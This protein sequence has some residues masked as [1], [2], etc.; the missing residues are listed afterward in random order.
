MLPK[1]I[2]MGRFEDYLNDF[3]STVNILDFIINILVAALL[4]FIIKIFYIKFA[5]TF[6][7]REKFSSIFLP[8]AL[9]TLLIITVVKASI[10]LSLGLVGALS[11]VRF[12]AA[13]KEPEELTYIF[14]IIGI[15]LTCGANKPMLAIAAIALILP[16]I[17]LNTRMG[18][19]K[20]MTKDKLLINIRTAST[21]V[22]VISKALSQNLKYVELKRMEDNADGLFLTFVTQVDDVQSISVIRQQLKS[23]DQNM[24]LT[25]IDQP[26]LIV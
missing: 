6:S 1:E 11:I 8:M 17:Y 7:N 14:L 10:A 24:Q 2:T 12:R 13:I 23:L 26:E 5:T 15:G 4:S 3:T 16:L 25:I 20:V 19:R 22:D 18:N 21:D 9:S